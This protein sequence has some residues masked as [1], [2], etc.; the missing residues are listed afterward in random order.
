MKTA[1]LLLIVSAS[2][3]ELCVTPGSCQPP[4]PSSGYS[5]QAGRNTAIPRKQWGDSGGFCGAVSI[6]TI[7][8]S[9]G[10]YISQDL[11]RKAAGPGNP[12]GHGHDD[13]GYEILH[14]NIDGALENLSL[15]YESWDYENAPK[16]QGK[17]YLAWMKAKLT[18]D[19]G[20]VQFVLC[21]GDR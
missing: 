19:A 9:Y 11:I 7:A 10:A 15:S 18:A 1:A 4:S 13:E 20:V 3:D 8:L 14:S 21:Q 5:F 16:P 2:A 17:D 6:Q 12:P